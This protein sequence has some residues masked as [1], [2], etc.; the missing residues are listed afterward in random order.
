V[1]ISAVTTCVNYGDFLAHTILW[2]KP[3]FDKFV[4]VSDRSDRR[5]RDICEHHYV[6]CIT[7]DLFYQNE[8]AFVKSNGINFGLDHLKATDWLVHMDADIVLPPR[9]RDLVQKAQLDRTCIYGVD[10]LMCRTFDEWLEYIAYPEVQHSCDIYVQ[11]NAFPLGVRIAK[12]RDEGYAPIGFFQMWHASS[13]R[14]YPDHGHADRSDLAFALQWPRGKRALIPEI[15]AI[16]LASEDGG[17]LGANWR[18]R[19]SGSFGPVPARMISLKKKDDY[20]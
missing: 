12:L 3:H 20:Q 5:T 18:G 10:R 14:T 15:F 7:T 9:F 6:E 4:V 16:H 17:D 11:G 1:N 19:R 2:N 8:R 13:R